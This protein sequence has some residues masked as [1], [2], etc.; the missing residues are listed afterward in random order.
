MAKVS[1]KSPS[2]EFAKGGNTSMFGKQH[3]GP[4]EA[5]T[6][7]HTTKGDGGKFAAGGKTKMF[8]KG[9]ANTAEAGR[10]QKA[11]Q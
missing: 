7:G 3:A 2:V 11:S 10:V 6:T 4:Q 8:G 5:G 9:A 1:G